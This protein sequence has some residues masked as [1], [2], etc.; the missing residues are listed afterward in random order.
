MI[1]VKYGMREVTP[2]WEENVPGVGSVREI[3]PGG[4]I[5]RTFSNIHPLTILFSSSD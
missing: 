1:L 5:L 2:W 3:C 4:N